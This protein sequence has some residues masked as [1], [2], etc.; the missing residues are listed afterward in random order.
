MGEEEQGREGHGHRQGQVPG[1]GPF[2]LW[3][4][5]QSHADGIWRQG[6][7]RKN[8]VCMKYVH[9]EHEE[10]TVCYAFQVSDCTVVGV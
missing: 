7:L 3:V 10:S 4:H 9:N 2:R 8:I 5:V 6:D 1:D